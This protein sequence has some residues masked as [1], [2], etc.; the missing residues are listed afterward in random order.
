VE[1]GAERSFD[2]ASLEARLAVVSEPGDDASQGLGAL[3]EHRS[4]GVVLET[5]QRPSPSGLELALEQDVADH[6]TLAGDRVE[7]EEAG[8]GKLDTRPVAVEAPK[9]LVA[10]AHREDRGASCYGLAQLRSPGGQVGC[11][12]SLFPVLAAA[13]V[14][15]VDLADRGRIAGVDGPHLELELPPAGPG[16]E[17]GDVAAICIDVQV[18]RIEMSHD[19]LHAARSQ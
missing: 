13:D 15:E 3:V 6:P 1:I 5:G 9:E 18:V 4:S 17:D 11:D 12:Q 7:R 8:A 10:A 14:I 16:C 2:A 19:Q